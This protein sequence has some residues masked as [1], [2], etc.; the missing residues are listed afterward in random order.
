MRFVRC[1]L[2]D[3]QESYADAVTVLARLTRP[4]RIRSTYSAKVAG[5]MWECEVDWR[6]LGDLRGKGN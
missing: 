6:R 2:E 1:G 4:R 5:A 3:A